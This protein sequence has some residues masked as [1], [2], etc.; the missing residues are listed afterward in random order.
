MGKKYLPKKIIGRLRE[1]EIVLAQGGTAAD[2]CRRIGVTEQ[3]RRPGRPA[4]PIAVV[5]TIFLLLDISQTSG[6]E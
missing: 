3:M 1:A 4:S 6:P 2:A 5:H